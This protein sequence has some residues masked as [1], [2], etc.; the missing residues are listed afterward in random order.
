MNTTCQANA[1]VYIE[2]QAEKAYNLI[3]WVGPGSL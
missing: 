1:L 2:T 3:V